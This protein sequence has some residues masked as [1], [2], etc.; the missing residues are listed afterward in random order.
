MRFWNWMN[1]GE[2]TGGTAVLVLS[3]VI[4]TGVSWY[5]D[6]VTPALFRQELSA[7]DGEDIMVEINSPGGD[8]FAG[9][10]IYNMLRAHKGKVTCRVVGNAASAASIVAMAADPGALIMC[11]VSMMMIHNPWTCVGGDAEALREQADV[12]D[13][14]REVMVSAYMHRFNGTEEALI[15]LLD[16]E[17]WLTPQRAL[18]LG[19][20]DEIEGAAHEEESAAAAAMLGRYAALSREAMGA[21]RARMIPEGAA[22]P[23]PEQRDAALAQQLLH[24][25]DALIAAAFT[26]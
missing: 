14:I 12:L 24:E 2:E 23:Q 6:T 10:E 18:S 7:H 13:M 11:E 17:S 20:C 15:T 1:A 25:A 22:K 8:V 4:D 26:M 3:G 5:E 19:L 16:E 21:I 9:F